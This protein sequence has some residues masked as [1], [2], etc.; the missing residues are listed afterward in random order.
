MAQRNLSQDD[1]WDLGKI[2]PKTVR[3]FSDRCDPVEIVSDN[4]DE[5]S[6][7]EHIPQP[8]PEMKV[9]RICTVRAQCEPIAEYENPHPLISHLAVFSPHAEGG[10]Y[11]RFATDARRYFDVHGKENSPTV[12]FFSY[13]PQY[14]QME[15]EQKECYFRWRDAFRRGNCET[16]PFGYLLLHL[17]EILNL[18]PELIAPQACLASMIAMWRAYRAAYP[19]LDRY[20]SEWICDLC[21][22]YALPL[23]ADFE[24]ELR[25]AGLRN[26]TLHEFYLTGKET[27]CEL[28]FLSEY[29]YR[30]SKFYPERKALYAE[31]ITG[32]VKA[33]G[34]DWLFDPAVCVPGCDTKAERECFAGALVCSSKRRRI[35]AHYRAVTHSPLAYRCA[36]A[37]YKYA[38]NG[39]R[40][41]L[42]IRA[43]LCVTGLPDA[44]RQAIDSYY[45]ARM[46]KK[47]K[48]EPQYMALYESTSDSLCT[49]RAKELERS[50]W[51]VTRLLTYED[52]AEQ[53]PVEEPQ[54]KNVTEPQAKDIP[55][56]DA[57]P[58]FPLQ[59][60]AFLGLRC[61]LDGD[62][63]A[64]AAVAKQAGMMAATLAEHINDLLYD[65][66]GDIAVEGDGLTQP[67][68]VIDCYLQETEAWLDARGK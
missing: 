16:V 28:S 44:A 45:A 56:N 1:F 11:E 35:A 53:M 25:L 50:S 60:P 9:S 33:V 42:G 31:H 46:P 65:V 34:S 55:V 5:I 23:P 32:A 14:T 30:K 64:F 66:I 29:D 7:S 61:L 49:E 12:P 36:T 21:L 37:I 20:L 67:F 18:T 40:A 68:A 63:C 17:Y 19:V 43:R 4:G 10:F 41:M 2:T 51:R 52:E 38:E 15:Y 22:L 57:S 24:Q 54:E 8:S 62:P 58:D 6:R 48:E 39:L 3:R 59:D 47:T 27:A 13:M 26:C